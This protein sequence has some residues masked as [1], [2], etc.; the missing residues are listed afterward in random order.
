IG[1]IGTSNFQIVPAN[2]ALHFWDV[3]SESWKPVG[4]GHSFIREYAKTL[5]PG[6]K[7]LVVPAARG[8]SSILE[9]EARGAL[10]YDMNQRIQRALQTNPESRVVAILW[11]QSESDIL[12]TVDPNVYAEKL[13]TVFSQLRSDVP[14]SFPILVGEPVPSWLAG[15]LSKK[16]IVG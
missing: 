4:I 15:N 13:K 16:A 2:R 12:S 9:W 11:H 8:G 1:R 5:S 7:V 14:G 3:A 6:R 10:Y